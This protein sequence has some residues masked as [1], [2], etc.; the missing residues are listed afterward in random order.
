MT[1]YRIN[2][3]QELWS[4]ISWKDIRDV[5]GRIETHGAAYL[6]GTL[7]VNMPKGYTVGLNRGGS[8]WFIPDGG[9]IG[10]RLSF[11]GLMPKDVQETTNELYDKYKG[12]KV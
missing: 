9:P 4:A 3:K 8:A 10:A 6:G 11:G 12:S 7:C 2:T 5:L 1:K